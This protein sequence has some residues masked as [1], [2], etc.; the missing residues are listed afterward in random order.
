M[1]VVAGAAVVVVAGADVAFATSGQ[2]DP[3]AVPLNAPD[4][5]APAGQH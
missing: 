5:G 3:D 2:H 4:L 1:V